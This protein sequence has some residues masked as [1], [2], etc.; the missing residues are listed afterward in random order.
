MFEFVVIFYVFVYSVVFKDCS[1]N[2][3]VDNTGPQSVYFI[4]Y[5]PLSWLK[6][7]TLQDKQKVT[8]ANPL[9]LNPGITQSF[10]IFTGR[11]LIAWLEQTKLTNVL[12][13]VT[14]MRFRFY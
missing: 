1:V 13:Q 11:Q 10:N 6:N 2:L 7:M 14:A 5:T 8:K 12:P 3:R 4:F 9:C